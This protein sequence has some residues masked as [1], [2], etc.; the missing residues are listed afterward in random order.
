MRA[1]ASVGECAA[2]FGSFIRPKNVECGDF[3][4]RD[5][6]DEEDEDEEDDELD[7]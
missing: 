4:E 1:A 2:G 7:S 5:L 3:P 6:L